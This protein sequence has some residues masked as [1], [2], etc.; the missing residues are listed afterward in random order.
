MLFE[1]ML[2]QS[3]ETHLTDLDPESEW[4]SEPD[5]EP[6]CLEEGQQCRRRQDGGGRVD[7]AC[8][9]RGRRLPLPI[10]APVRV[11]AAGNV[12]ELQGRG[13]HGHGH[14]CRRG[15]NSRRALTERATQLRIPTDEGAILAA[16]DV[17]GAEPWHLGHVHQ[18]APSPREAHGAL[19]LAGVAAL[20]AEAPDPGPPV[21]PQALVEPV[22]DVWHGGAGLAPAQRKEGRLG[23]GRPD[24]GGA[25]G[26]GAALR[27]AGHFGALESPPRG[28]GARVGHA[29]GGIEGLAG[30][31]RLPPRS[32]QVVDAA[33]Q[34][35][36]Q[37]GGA[38]Q[39]Q[40][41]HWQGVEGDSGEAHIFT[42][43]VGWAEV[44]WG[45]FRLALECDIRG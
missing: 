8:R 13:G 6:G 45:L 18:S 42:V 14:G 17:C 19:T 28:A 25:V 2:L 12:A 11:P 5:P 4:K 21:L 3:M 26:I 29:V 15:G 36:G 41:G 40:Q 31:E 38:E 9:S 16:P 24:H 30:T 43:G 23:R 7:L 34:R 1:F 39:Q 10:A 44:G 20:G 27:H 33:V 32:A 22:C 37:G 35:S